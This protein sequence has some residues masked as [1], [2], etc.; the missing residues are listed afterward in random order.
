[1]KTKIENLYRF[2]NCL[3]DEES[4]KL[5]EVKIQQLMYGSYELIKYLRDASYQGWR[6]SKID[7]FRDIAF[8]KKLIIRGAGIWGELTYKILESMGIEVYAFCD[9]DKEKQELGLF[10]KKVISESM[11][12]ADYKDA[13]VLVASRIKGGEL[14]SSL[15]EK[16]F[17][18][19][20]LFLPRIGS[21]YATV[22]E[23]YFDCPGF[24]ID[25]EEVFVDCGCF[26]GETS[27]SFAKWCNYKY[28]KIVAF[29]P[30][31]YM[32]Y[33]I[34]ENCK[35]LKDFELFSY[36]VGKERG[37]VK[38]VSGANG[39]S[40]LDT[41]GDDIKI[42]E[43]IDNVLKGERATFL[44]MDIE[45]AELNA[46]YGSTETIR[47]YKPKLAIC[48]YH[49]L[50]DIIEIPKAIMSIRDDYKFYIRHYSSCLWETV[51]YAV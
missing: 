27:K 6:L 3:Q 19:E 2:Y 37:K 13:F 46:I 51:L 9:N 8:G 15:L 32:N 31:D 18:R 24:T 48:I 29:E 33:R 22:G 34:I 38:F 1:M 41:L 40:R 12:I 10:G 25:E 16:F 26:D 28:K 11:L 50:E 45:G 4:R 44:K 30:D 43:S 14:Y 7:D 23:Q 49:R 21:I 36:A 47:K 17:P 5:F 39:G 20:N 42:I 35:E